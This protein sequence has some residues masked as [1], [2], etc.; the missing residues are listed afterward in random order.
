MTGLILAVLAA[1]MATIAPIYLGRLKPGYSHVRHTFSEFG[2]AGSPVGRAVSLYG[3]LTAVLSWGSLF[4]AAQAAPQV[5]REIFFMFSLVGV[6]YLGGSI[7]PCDKDAPLFGS[8]R[9][10]FHNIFAGLEYLGAAGAFFALER[11]FGPPLSH[12]LKVAGF[13]VFVGFFGA[14]FPHRYRGLSQR[15]AETIIFGGMVVMSWWIY[16][17]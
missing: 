9:T 8:W 4:F 10:L 14:T 2:E 16:R 12:V 11:Y 13:I 5:S 17:A 7:F 15:I 6:A 1:A 3:V